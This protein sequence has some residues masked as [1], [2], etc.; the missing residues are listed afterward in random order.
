VNPQDLLPSAPD[1]QPYPIVVMED[2]EILLERL[3]QVLG[4]KG[5]QVVRARSLE[6]CV[7]LLA[8]AS[9][10]VVNTRMNGDGREREGMRALQQLKFVNPECF[11]A[12]FADQ[13]DFRAEALELGCDTFLLKTA[14]VDSIA[15]WVLLA[16]DRMILSRATNLSLAPLQRPRAEFIAQRVVP[17][18]P[19]AEIFERYHALESKNFESVLSD[20][21]QQELAELERQIGDIE[22]QEHA[23]FERGFR[24]SKSGRLEAALDKVEELLTTWRSGAVA[25]RR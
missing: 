18:R 3:Q 6:E 10:F 8:R 23:R 4:L 14:D 19:Q 15:D 16:F 7:S 5:V 25:G 20:S 21:E 22:N 13:P 9:F 24:E 17:M 1:A 11:V 12:L 2:D